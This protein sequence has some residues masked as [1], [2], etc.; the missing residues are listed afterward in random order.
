MARNSPTANSPIFRIVDDVD[1]ICWYLIELGIQS[2]DSQFLEEKKCV[3]N[4]TEQTLFSFT[5][6][7]VKFR[8][9]RHRKDGLS[10]FCHCM[11]TSTSPF[12]SRSESALHTTKATSMSELFKTFIIICSVHFTDRILSIW[13]LERKYRPPFAALTCLAWRP[14]ARIHNV[15]HPALSLNRAAFVFLIRRIFGAPK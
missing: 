9:I 15:A 11:L 14:R 12:Y 5:Q 3:Q 10:I 2:Y 8:W 13:L 7:M 6:S 4:F 1:F